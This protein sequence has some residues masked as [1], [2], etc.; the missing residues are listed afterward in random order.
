MSAKR[1]KRVAWEAS[2][3]T[4]AEGVAVLGGLF[5]SSGDPRADG[6]GEGFRRLVAAWQAGERLA[7]CSVSEHFRELPS[8]ATLPATLNASRLYSHVDVLPCLVSEEGEEISV[9]WGATSVHPGDRFDADAFARVLSEPQGPCLHLSCLHLRHPGLTAF[10]LAMDAAL[11]GEG[12]CHATLL[13]CAGCVCA[14]PTHSRAEDALL[15]CLDGVFEAT[16]L[17]EACEGSAGRAEATA[18]PD[19]HATPLVC[20]PGV[21]DQENVGVTELEPGRCL[22]VPQGC[23]FNLV[24]VPAR[25]PDG[26]MAD[27]RAWLLEPSL[28]LLVTLPHQTPWEAAMTGALDAAQGTLAALSS[29][30][31]LFPHD[32]HA[33]AAPPNALLHATLRSLFAAALD[34]VPVIGSLTRCSGLS[35]QHF[36]VGDYLASRYDL[37]AMLSA[38]DGLVIIRDFLPPVV[39][40]RMRD[41][42][43]CIREDEWVSTEAEYNPDENNIQHAF[44]SSSAFPNAAAI[45]G[46]LGRLMPG[47]RSVISAASYDEPGHGIHAHDDRAERH[48]CGA[49]FTRSVAVVLH[50]SQGWSREDG[51]LFVDLQRESE[52]H[53][54]EF[55]TLVAFKVPRMHAV[56]P[57]AESASQPRLSLFGWF[58]EP[59]RS[60]DGLIITTSS[61]N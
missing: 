4:H 47:H 58:L 10:L 49:V 34:A 13:A 54:P 51:G 14:L 52:E 18:C 23:V 21:F 6:N 12:G 50:L 16:A 11:R 17:A 41:T 29:T 35:V 20:Y 15:V 56:T 27:T 36:D 3:P 48:I 8:L 19:V 44:N 55:N 38:S 53:V 59:Q 39:A 57:V 26:S 32:V 37:S 9:A 42:L 22:F 46:A 33:A 30:S 1:Q 5:R 2:V 25:K 28:C 43:L 40:Q 24:S 60:P 7:S 31:R 45:R 61:I